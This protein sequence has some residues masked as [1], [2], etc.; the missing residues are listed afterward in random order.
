MEGRNVFQV[1]GSP[2]EAIVGAGTDSGSQL[3]L[4]TASGNVLRVQFQGVQFQFVSSL[5]RFTNLIPT[6]AL[7]S[8]WGRLKARYR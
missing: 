5:G 2:A 7:R 3:Y 1:L 8:T 6:T 4:L